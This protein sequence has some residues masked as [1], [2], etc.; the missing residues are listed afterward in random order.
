MGRI[1][2]N[3][4]LLAISTNDYW[5]KNCL[6]NNYTNTVIKYRIN[7]LI[8]GLGSIGKKTDGR[9]RYTPFDPDKRPKSLDIYVRNNY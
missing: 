6:I 1:A 5:L 9:L 8:V 7:I 3:Y 2:T 4:Y